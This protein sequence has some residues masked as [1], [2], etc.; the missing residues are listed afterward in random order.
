MTG[1]LPAYMQWKIHH[2]GRMHLSSETSDRIPIN[3]ALEAS[4]CATGHH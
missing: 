2:H 1:K 3:L 4:Q